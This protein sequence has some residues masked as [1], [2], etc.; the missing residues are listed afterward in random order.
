MIAKIKLFL[1]AGLGVVTA[2]LYGLLQRQKTQQ[3]DEH[4][5][6]AEHSAGK[7]KDAAEAMVAGLEKENNLE[8]ID[9]NKPRDHFS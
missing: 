3:A 8:N 6:I 4:A 2:V 9:P 5:Q 1:I 7:T